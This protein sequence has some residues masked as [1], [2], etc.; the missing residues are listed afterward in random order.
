MYATGK[1]HEKPCNLYSP[2]HEVISGHKKCVQS[3]MSVFFRSQCCKILV[4]SE[5]R[6]LLSSILHHS[7]EFTWSLVL[8][9][10]P[11]RAIPAP[12]CVLELR[13]WGG[14]GGEAEKSGKGGRK[15]Q[16]RV[17][18]FT[19]P[20]YGSDQWKLPKGP[21][22]TNHREAAVASASNKR[23][24]TFERA[25][26]RECGGRSVCAWVCTRARVCVWGWETWTRVS[27]KPREGNVT[28]ARLSTLRG[29]KSSLKL[30]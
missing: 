5:R 13:T 15:G 14:G 23:L 27:E 17:R 16:P 24:R 3:Y 6:V 2:P 21:G 25:R 1:K 8:Y 10:R 9:W 20:T 4:N 11:F 18:S 19:P 26:G 28:C 7:A 12:R 30:F 22:L 29:Q